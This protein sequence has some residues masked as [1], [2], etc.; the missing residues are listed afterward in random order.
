MRLSCERLQYVPGVLLRF[1]NVIHRKTIKKLCLLGGIHRQY[2]EREVI[3][4]YRTYQK[5]LSTLLKYLPFHNGEINMLAYFRYHETTKLKILCISSLFN[6][7]RN[8]FF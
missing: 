1:S 5:P 2:S 3:A 4:F 8:S 6:T 7:I